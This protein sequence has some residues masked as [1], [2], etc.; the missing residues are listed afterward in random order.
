MVKINHLLKYLDYLQN[1]S[2]FHYTLEEYVEQDMLRVS[3]YY[4]GLENALV[5]PDYQFLNQ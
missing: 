4:A 1:W 3:E 5:F 2:Y